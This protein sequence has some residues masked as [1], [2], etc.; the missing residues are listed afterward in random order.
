MRTALT[1]SLW[2]I[3]LAALLLVAGCGPSV[4]DAP[5]LPTRTEQAIALLPS[6]ARFAGMLD[7]QD[8]QENGG[9]SFTSER[10]ITVQF[11]DSDVTFNPLSAEQQDRLEAFI[12]ATGF[13]PGSDLHAAY[14]AGDST[15]PQA[16]LLAASYERDRLTS[17]L[18]EQFDGRLDTTSYQGAPILRLRAEDEDVS[19]SSDTPLQFA[20]LDDGWMAL[21]ADTPRL[22]AII[23]RSL[24]ADAPSDAPSMMPLVTR[25]G[26]RGGAWI[27]VRDLPSQRMAQSAGEQRLARLARAVRDAGM[28][29]SFR[30]DGVDGT[31]LLTTDQDP[32]DVAD[33]VRGAL[34]TLK[35]QS[36]LTTEQEELLDRI[37]VIKAGDERVWVTFDVPQ[38]TLARILIQSMR[39]GDGGRLTMAR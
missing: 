21:S 28:A 9:L 3:P 20:L 38:E 32:S 29:L 19:S 5:P 8:L 17:V 27:A 31:I 15:Q 25:L 37:T 18:V 24:A 35:L 11:L 12:E 26:G 2:A 6:D 4:D 7:L 16:V 23:D 39:D 30:P 36:N 13:E 14:V 34:S 1:R 10:G 33:V 22:R